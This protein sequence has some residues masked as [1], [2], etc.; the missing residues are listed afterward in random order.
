MRGASVISSIMN[1]QSRLEI[2]HAGKVGQPLDQLEAELGVDLGARPSPRAR[3]RRR[4]G[5]SRPRRSARNA[6]AASRA[7]AS[8]NRAWWRRPRRRRASSAWRAS[9]AAMRGAGL[10][11]MGDDR[12]CA[13]SRVLEREFEQRALLPVGEADRLA[14][15]HRQRERVGAVARYG[16]RSAWRSGRRSMRALARERRHRR[17]HEA[18]LE[19][20]MDYFSELTSRA[21]R[22]RGCR[23]LR[24]RSRM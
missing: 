15:M 6:R 3:C 11:D 4:T 23:A 17:V 22:C 8:S 24:A 1:C 19:D 18:W 10:A 13:R 12:A 9:A 14:D 2:D 7:A 20:G 16:I 5:S 21:A